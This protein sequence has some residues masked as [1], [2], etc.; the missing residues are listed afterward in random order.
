M[1]KRSCALALLIMSPSTSVL[2]QAE[3]GAAATS[4]PAAAASPSVTTGANPFKRAAPTNGLPP[5]PPVAGA[6]TGTAVT[7]GAP[8][9]APGAP[10]AY[11]VPETP[12]IP[13]KGRRI[14]KV[15]DEIVYRKD[16][17]YSFETE[18]PPGGLMPAPALPGAGTV[19]A[20]VVATAGTVVQGSAGPQPV[21]TSTSST[22][23]GRV[24]VDPSGPKPVVPQ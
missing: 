15:G 12:Q 14:G 13:T 17:I 20:P 11:A 16:G 3:P 19:I 2:A 1:L 8:P 18:T 6:A 4:T 22:N 21:A 24:N 10:P 9:G 7:T 23:D 5:P